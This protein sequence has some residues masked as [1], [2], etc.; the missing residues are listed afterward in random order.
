MR[1]VLAGA[2]Y[3]LILLALLV[4]FLFAYDRFVAERRALDQRSLYSMDVYP[5]TGFHIQSHFSAPADLRSGDD[6][7]FIDFPIKSPP[8]KTSDEYRI[9]LTGGSAA[10]GVLLPNNN[11]TLPKML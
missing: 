2:I 10:Q 5:Y 4:G 6:G 9:I 8:P 7:F 3:A 1:N 11:A